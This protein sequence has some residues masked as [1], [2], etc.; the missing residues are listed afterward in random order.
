[1]KKLIYFAIATLLLV[2]C[3]SNTVD[4][5]HE[6]PCDSI[7]ESTALDKIGNPDVLALLNELKDAGCNEQKMV[8][9]FYFNTQ[10]ESEVYLVC[11][12]NVKA[13]DKLMDVYNNSND[14]EQKA[15]AK[16][17]LAK[18]DS[19]RNAT[20]ATFDKSYAIILKYLDKLN[21][22]A[23]ASYRYECHKGGR[24]TILAAVSFDTI[25]NEVDEAIRKANDGDYS[26]LHGYTSDLLA[27]KIKKGPKED[28]ISVK[29]SRF[30]KENDMHSIVP[31]DP[32]TSAIDDIIMM[33][34]S[35]YDVKSVD[36]CFR[37][38]STFYPNNNKD[39][40]MVRG[41]DRIHEKEKKAVGRHYFIPL[42]EKE[43]QALTSKLQSRLADY[44]HTHRHSDFCLDLFSIREY[45]TFSRPVFSF[46]ATYFDG[47]MEPLSLEDEM[48][49]EKSQAYIKRNGTRMRTYYWTAE[50][51]PKGLHLLRLTAGPNVYIPNKWTEVRKCHNNKMESYDFEFE[52]PKV[53]SLDEVL[54]LIEGKVVTAKQMER[55][56]AQAGTVAKVVN[57]DNLLPFI[58]EKLDLRKITYDDDDYLSALEYKKK[59]G[60]KAM[61][62]VIDVRTYDVVQRIK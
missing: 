28:L 31:H 23:E 19:I 18:A 3:N 5:Q 37:Y 35:K 7:Y 36:V 10:V 58:N 9:S 17:A 15:K 26:R 14:G 38:D 45:G 8:A 40:I 27:V 57:R 47:G 48:N 16:N 39:V 61:N 24:D 52:F 12:H 62:G 20:K 44:C 22:S 42:A 30:P 25:P 54:L 32:D 1:M 60:D 55:F 51:T 34:I 29:Y 59:Y 6:V 41:N 46:S 56:V 33:A 11:P 53:S 43:R 50:L 4:A 21:A 2:S 49:Y 13:P